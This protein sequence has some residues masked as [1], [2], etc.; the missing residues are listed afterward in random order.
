VTVISGDAR[1]QSLPW[2]QVA[3]DDIAARGS[4]HTPDKKRA[5]YWN[6]SILWV[7]LKDTFRLDRGLISRTTETITRMGLA[8]SSAVVHPAG[9]VILL[10]DAGIGKSSVLG[11]DMAVSQHFMAWN[12]GPRLDNWFLY[13]YLQS[14]KPE[15]ERI[16]NGST[17]KTIG[18]DYF[19]QLEIPLPTL[20]E[21]RQIA[22]TLRDAD[23]LISA[24]ERVIAKKQ[25]IKQGLMQQLLTGKTRLPGF[26]DHWRKV[27][28][29]DE[30]T[31]YGGLVGKDKNDFGAGSASFVTFMEV[32]A[33]ARL[34][35]HRLERVRVRSGERQNQ[36]QRGDVLF[37]GSSETPEEVAL[38]AVVEF[39]P[40]PATYLNSFCFGYRLKNTRLIDPTFL[41][42]FFRS[43]NGRELVAS[44][45]QGATRYNIAKTKLLEVQPSLPPVDEQR[46]IVE[47]LQDAESELEA[48][49]IRLTK[50]RAV[51]TGMLQQLLTGRTRLPV[52]G[53]AA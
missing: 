34:L 5:D 31:T 33:S 19:R 22:Q 47:V 49:G 10:R 21:Q 45:A 30:G 2:N 12:C 44:L 41:A 27:K 15:L 7:S 11:A 13:Y 1:V 29:R 25:A 20:E 9:S 24:L 48:L 40:S 39:N 46:A 37:N 32:M 3:L 4:G 18:L 53:G 36:V 16:S 35:G 6:G 50:V 52:R 42:Y 23:D 17:I 8:N 51:K 28:L 43:G 38:A 14:M 26:T